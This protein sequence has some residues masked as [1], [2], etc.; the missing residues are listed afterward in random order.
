MFRRS[1]KEPLLERDVK[2]QWA[3]P[4]KET[5]EQALLSKRDLRA[6]PLERLLR[7]EA[8]ERL[9]HALA[10]LSEECANALILHHVLGFQQAEIA[11]MTHAKVSTVAMRIQ[12]GLAALR[13]LLTYEDVEDLL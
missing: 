13:K 5:P 2:R 12:R 9:D 11:E 8:A 3:L 4:P 7:A 1:D 10:Q 6:D